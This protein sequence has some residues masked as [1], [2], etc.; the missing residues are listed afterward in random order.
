[1]KKCYNYY[2]FI[3]LIS[4]S[5][6][7][8]DQLKVLKKANTKPEEATKLA[9]TIYSDASVSTNY[10]PLPFCKLIGEKLLLS[11]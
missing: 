3:I 1:M 6:I 11:Y 10:L 4:L 8:N 2:Y 9:I 5:Y 7:R